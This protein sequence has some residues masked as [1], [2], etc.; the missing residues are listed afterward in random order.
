MGDFDV[1]VF[2][3]ASNWFIAVP[4]FV[5]FIVMVPIVMLNSLIALMSD[6]FERVQQNTTAA[7]RL[8]RAKII[9]ELEHLLLP[10]VGDTEGSSC[11]QWRI[12]PVACVL[13]VQKFKVSSEQFL[14][15]LEPKNR[16]SQDG[17]EWQGRMR[18]LFKKFERAESN[19]KQ[20]V[21]SIQSKLQQQVASVESKVQQHVG[22]V[23]EDV[24]A[25][26]KHVATVDSKL[27]DIQATLQMI[28]AASQ[29]RPE[30]E[31]E[32]EPE[33]EPELDEDEDSE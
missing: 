16:D 28:L 1:D 27:N 19:H 18:V 20:Q 5:T 21:A 22:A 9:L 33:L 32:P 4:L 3:L 6:T 8:E 30:P 25:V 31:P 23:K 7:S 2:R 17:S 29:T 24:E 13:L 12:Y 26:K 14:H 15:V 10:A 11:R